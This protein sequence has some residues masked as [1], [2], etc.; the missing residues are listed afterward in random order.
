MQFKI[1][2]R[3][4]A[5]NEAGLLAWLTYIRDSHPTQVQ[6]A[7]V[8]SQSLSCNVK[9]VVETINDAVAAIQ[10]FRENFEVQYGLAVVV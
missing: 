5:E 1:N 6:D 2:I 10:G 7:S 9:L 8:E 3:H 4:N